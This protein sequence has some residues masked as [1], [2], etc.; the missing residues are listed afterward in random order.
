[1]DIPKF[2]APRFRATGKQGYEIPYSGL[3]AAVSHLGISSNMITFPCRITRIKAIY[4]DDAQNLVRHYFIYDGNR[5]VSTTGVSSG[6]NILRG[7]APLG[8]FLGKASIKRI[9]VNI[10]L[11]DP[12]TFIKVHTYNGAPTAYYINCGVSIEEL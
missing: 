4:T 9:F 2:T 10:E 11:P 12:P 8:Y 3:V 1:M 7:V 6:I 5:T